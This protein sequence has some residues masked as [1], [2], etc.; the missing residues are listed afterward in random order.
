[1][2]YPHY[3]Y[4]SQTNIHTSLQISP[5]PSSSQIPDFILIC[6]LVWSLGIIL[7]F[8]LLTIVHNQFVRK[9]DLLFKD[10]Q[11]FIMENH[12]FQHVGIIFKV[13]ILQHTSK[14]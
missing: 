6:Y 8:F 4:F 11:D 1:M 14:E 13:E 9:S 10:K 3:K 2:F 7:D 5:E 12:C